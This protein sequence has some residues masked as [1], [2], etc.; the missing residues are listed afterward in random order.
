[1]CLH[2]LANSPRALLC[3]NIS[4]AEQAYPRI[5][6]VHKL[7]Q[8]LRARQWWFSLEAGQSKVLGQEKAKAKA[9]GQAERPR[10][11]A[12]ASCGL[13]FLN[14][15]RPSLP[16]ASVTELHFLMFCE[17][18]ASVTFGACQHSPSPQ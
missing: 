2:G 3:L 14:S 7:L 1:M 4:T 15:P 18:Q 5:I 6:T 12:S 17:A 8:L 16:G 13:F 11:W 10:S 9:W